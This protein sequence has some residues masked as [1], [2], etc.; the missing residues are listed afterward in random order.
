MA[1]VASRDVQ[2]PAPSSA[3]QIADALDR[4]QTQA[5]GRRPLAAHGGAVRAARAAIRGLAPGRG[6]ARRR[7]RPRARARGALPRERRGPAAPRRADEAHR[8]AE[9]AALEPAWLRP[10]PRARG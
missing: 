10:V 6:L 5:P 4:F 9:R 7:R 3:M 2:G 1:T 8:L